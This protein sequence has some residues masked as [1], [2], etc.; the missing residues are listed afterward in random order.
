MSVLFRVLQP[1]DEEA[2][3][4]FLLPRIETSAFLLS[5]LR[6][7]G[8]EN[9]GQ[10]FQGTYA[11]AFQGQRIVGVVSLF[12][13][14]GLH[15]QTPQRWLG[16]LIHTA[17]QASPQPLDRLLGPSNQVTAVLKLLDI[18]PEDCQ[19]D[20]KQVLYSLSLRELVVPEALL[21]GQIGGR[22][23][24]PTGPARPPAG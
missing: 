10:R 6:E 13:N 7:A 8:L 11:A 4:S 16:D 9:H 5:N 1:G 14:G 23:A 15:V 22:H 18:A 2:L 12:W 19:I 24:R 17:W 20:E 3:E 21:S